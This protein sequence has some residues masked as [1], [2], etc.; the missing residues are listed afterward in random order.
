MEKKMVR[1]GD[2]PPRTRAVIVTV[3]AVDI[4]LRALALADLRR[5]SADD[6]NGPKAAWATALAV[7]SSA[8]AVPG[9][10]FLLGRRRS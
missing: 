8:G 6:V 7:V 4:C 1:W 9:A 2:L 10:Y 3:G 5:R